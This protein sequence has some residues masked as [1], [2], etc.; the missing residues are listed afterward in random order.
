MKVDIFCGPCWEPFT[1]D[2]LIKGG[3]GGSE[4]ATIHMAREFQALGHEV[5]VWTDAE[6]TFDG[7][8]YVNHSKW[9]PAASTGVLIAWRNV[10][11]FTID[12]PAKFKILWLHDLGLP[13]LPDT[14]SNR[15]TRIAVLSEFHGKTVLTTNPT[16][17][18]KLWHVGNG[19]DIKL[20][21]NIHGIKDSNSYIYSSSPRR[22]LQKLLDEW[23]AVRAAFPN[24]VLNVAYGFDLTIA[25]ET[26]AGNHYNARAYERMLEQCKTIEGV[27]YHGR[28]S[29][30]KLAALQWQCAAWLYP[31]S[32]FEETYCITAVEMQAAMCWP[33][34]RLNGGL[35]DVI[36]AG[37]V[38]TNNSTAV[39]QIAM[40]KNNPPGEDLLMNNRKVALERSWKH[41]AEIWSKVFTC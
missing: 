10:A 18:H 14:I 8:K 3:I 34:T 33:I 12:T 32:D 27:K 25:M 6:G 19:I 7:V 2:S 37:Q 23:P 16:L 4:T 28:L 11:P 31:P 40:Y 39:E 17:K 13:A 41:Q 36:N 30:D 5:T 21:E 26:K 9:N 20:Y 22:G 38:W 15:I 1:P 29:H 24:S 35:P